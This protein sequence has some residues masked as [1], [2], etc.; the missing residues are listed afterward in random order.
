ME[1][2][3]YLAYALLFDYLDRFYWDVLG[4]FLITLRVIFRV[5]FLKYDI[6]LIGC[7]DSTPL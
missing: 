7:P 1:Q 2:S 5:V 4:Y 3:Q 6:A